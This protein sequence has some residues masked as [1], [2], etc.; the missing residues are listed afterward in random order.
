MGAVHITWRALSHGGVQGGERREGKARGA[1][2]GANQNAV[3]IEE[4]DSVESHAIALHRP[5]DHASPALSP[6]F[7][8]STRSDVSGIDTEVHQPTASPPQANKT[9]DPFRYRSRT[10]SLVFYCRQRCK[11]NLYLFRDTC[12]LSELHSLDHRNHRAHSD[13]EAVWEQFRSN[14][15]WTIA[16]LMMG[17]SIANRSEHSR[18]VLPSCAICP[19]V[20][21]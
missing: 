10:V 18:R 21:S 2:S 13:E 7:P 3:D 8:R 19:R 11:Y 6:C 4:Y 15:V 1:R 16:P 9:S 12:I 20:P 5:R 17:Q 14:V